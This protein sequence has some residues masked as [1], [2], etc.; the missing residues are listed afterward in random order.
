MRGL[1]TTVRDIV[2]AFAVL[3]VVLFLLDHMNTSHAGA[4]QQSSQSS[5]PGAPTC[6]VEAADPG[7]PESPQAVDTAKR[8]CDALTGKGPGLGAGTDVPTVQETR[9]A[10]E[11]LHRKGFM[12]DVDCNTVNPSPPYYYHH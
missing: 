7:S 3:L 11:D 9:Q 4:P 2:I 8:L 6:T 5:D 10:C 1:I 12:L